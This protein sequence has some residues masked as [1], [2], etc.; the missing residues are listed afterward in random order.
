MVIIRDLYEDPSFFYDI[1]YSYV[2]SGIPIV[3]AMH[4]K[5]HAVTIIGHGPVESAVSTVNALATRPT[6]LNARHCSRSLV[7][8]NDNYLPFQHLAADEQMQTIHNLNDVD[9]FVVPLYEKMYLAA[10]NVLKIYPKWVAMNLIDV[11]VASTYISRVFMTSSRSYKRSLAKAKSMNPVFRRAQ[12]DLPMPKFIWIVE[13]AEPSVYDR[14]QANYRWILDATANPREKYSFLLIH[15]DEK[16]IINDRAYRDKIYEVPLSNGI[17]QF[18]LF[19]N[20]LGRY[21]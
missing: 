18:S 2:E 4:T 14:Q 5:S 8:N 15:D 21:L 7:I 17:N 6:F 11:K 3:A 1:L 13:L 12:L 9:G 10:D 16:M 19:E 20:N